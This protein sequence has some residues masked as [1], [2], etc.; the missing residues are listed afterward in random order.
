MILYYGHLLS[1]TCRAFL[2]HAVRW[3]YAALT[4]VKDEKAHFIWQATFLRALHGFRS[5][6]IRWALNIKKHF[7]KRE[8]THLV[9]QVAEGTRAQ[10]STVVQV[11]PT[12]IYSVSAALTSAIDRAQAAFDARRAQG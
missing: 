4:A 5:A 6:V 2:R 12:G 7:T 1:E 11:G 8:H 10:F 9:G 3:W